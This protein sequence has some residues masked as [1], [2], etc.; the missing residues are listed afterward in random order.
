MKRPTIAL[1]C[2]LKN[3][4]KNLPRLLASVEG[5]F[6]EI[7]LTDTGSTDGSIEWIGEYAKTHPEVQLHHFTWCDDFSAARNA[8]FHPVKTDYVMWMDLDDVLSD[9]GKFTSWRDSIMKLADFWLATYHYALDAKGNPT[10]SFARERVFKTAHGLR[11]KYFVHEGVLPEKPGLVLQYAPTWNVRHLRDDQDL[12]A[13]KS[14]NLAIFEKHKGSLDARMRYYYGK[15]L[16][17]GGKT[18]DAYAAL[19]EAV[20]DP[21]LEGHDRIMGIQLA[22]MAAAQLGQMERAISLAHQGLALAPQRAEFLVVI[23]DCHLKENRTADAVPY[24]EAASKCQYGGDGPIQ[25]PIFQQGMAYRQYPLNQ[26]ARIYA[27][28][29]DLDRA[30]RYVTE[31]MRLAAD[32]ESAGILGDIHMMR[33]KI[34]PQRERVETRD[35]V[36][37]CPPQSLYEWDPKVYGERGVGGSETAAIE[38]AAWLQRLTKRRVIVFNPRAKAETFDGVEYRPTAEIPEY[39][40]DNKPAAVI[41]W[42]H[43]M[44]ISD[45]PTYVWCHDLGFPGLEN[46]Q[47][48][49]KVLTLSPFHRE[50][51][52]NFFSVP[53]EKL[54]VTRNG[55]EPKRFVGLAADKI[56]GKIVWSSSPDRGL[57]RAIRVMDLVVKRVPNAKLHVYYGFDNMRKMGMTA[58]IERIEKLM[59]GKDFIVFHG[60]ISQTE[61][62]KEIREACVWLYPTN[63]LETFCITGI[64]MLSAGVYPVARAWG[65]LPDTLGDAARDGMASLIDSDCSTDEEIIRFAEETVSALCGSRHELVRVD[66]SQFSWRSVAEEWIS[67]LGLSEDECQLSNSMQSLTA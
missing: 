39:F 64:E 16:F 15:E 26:L 13:D 11:W 1:A 4:L 12:K 19:M 62:T 48:Y 36:I 5:C 17:E 34:K 45:D 57:D 38:M 49:T 40:R 25:G 43:A 32:A 53:D 65:A 9:K 47:N 51:V 28:A 46:H 31:A 7:H 50:Y 59:A 29:G 2:I 55:I 54:A 20:T 6:D 21:T 18:L 23:A 37:T 66:A 44:K 24:Y 41:A 30:E 63:F 22:A 52:K 67:T 14:R 60:N 56:P 58:E 61:L 8:S 27:N 42:R 33:A 10:C 3:E 35:I